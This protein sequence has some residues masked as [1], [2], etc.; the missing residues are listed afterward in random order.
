MTI[1]YFVANDEALEAYMVTLED[2]LK[3]KISNGTHPLFRLY[4][5]V[6]EFS[7]ITDQDFIT[8]L[9]K[10]LEGRQFIQCIHDLFLQDK[11][12]MVWGEDL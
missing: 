7:G 9:I 5:E 4:D 2:H 3:L 12:V 10:T 8:F 11:F 1:S 6:I